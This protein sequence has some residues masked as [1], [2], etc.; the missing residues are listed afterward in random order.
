[1]VSKETKK[2]QNSPRKGP[3]SRQNTPA[4]ATGLTVFTD[5]GN[6]TDARW[7]GLV[8]L[9]LP[10]VVRLLRQLLLMGITSHPLSRSLTG[11]CD[12]L[13][14]IGP[15]VGKQTID[16]MFVFASSY[17][18]RV[19]WCTIQCF[20]SQ[21]NREWRTINSTDKDKWPTER[22]SYVKI[23]VLFETLWMSLRS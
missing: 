21:R 7:D 12:L 22:K 1:M 3:T 4:I 16:I 6:E 18:I 2:W 17:C 23:C 10:L 20:C 15:I 19:F 14:R 8:M 11:A 9:M 13:M 5:T